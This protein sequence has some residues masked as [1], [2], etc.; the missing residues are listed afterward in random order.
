MSKTLTELDYNAEAPEHFE[1]EP[2]SDTDPLSPGR[3]LVLALLKGTD[4]TAVRSALQSQVPQVVHLVAPSPAW[5]RAAA[6][7]IARSYNSIATI[8]VTEHKRTGNDFVTDQMLTRLTQ[9]GHVVI[10]ST[11]ALTSCP[12]LP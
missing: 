6:G 9:G 3:A 4:T 2:I 8:T 11:D 7:E 10:A 5:A 12:L 1:P